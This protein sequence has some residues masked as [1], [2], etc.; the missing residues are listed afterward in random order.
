MEGMA[1]NG[2]NGRKW[3][4]MDK[5]EEI[6]AGESNGMTV[7]CYNLDGVGPVDKRPSKN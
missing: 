6:D 1:V 7:Y 4:L 5:K 2:G 3:L